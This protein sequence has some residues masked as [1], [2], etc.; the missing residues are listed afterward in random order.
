MRNNF[1]KKLGLSL[2]AFGLVATSVFTGSDA[3]AVPAFARQTGMSCNSCHFQGFPS[4]NGMGRSFRAGGYTMK[5]TLAD[6][7][8]SETEP[9]SLPTVMPLAIFWKAYYVTSIKD[10]GTAAEL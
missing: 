6:I 1:A 9:M 2:A 7:E 5:G 10:E 4:L 8:G 3:Q